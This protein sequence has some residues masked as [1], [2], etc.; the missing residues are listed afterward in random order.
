M[1]PSTLRLKPKSQ[2]G[3]G[4]GGERHRGWLCRIFCGVEAVHLASNSQPYGA[5]LISS[6]LGDNSTI[7]L[8]R[9]IELIDFF[10]HEQHHNNSF[11]ASSCRTGCNMAAKALPMKPMHN[12]RSPD[13]ELVY[14][15]RFRNPGRE[16]ETQFKFASYATFLARALPSELNIPILLHLSK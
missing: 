6:Y 4:C 12:S 8:L 3:E 2:V 1:L 10:L 13:G 7:S 11:C 9:S 14:R 15:T 5:R 16:P